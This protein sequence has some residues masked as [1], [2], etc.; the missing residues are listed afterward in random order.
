MM[1]EKFADYVIQFRAAIIVLVAI[2]VAVFA[3][4]LKDVS[5]EGS[6]RIWFGKDAKILTNYLDFREQFG[7]DEGVVITFRTPSGVFNQKDLAVITSI[8]EN[9]S[10]MPYFSSVVSIASFPHMTVPKDDPENIEINPFIEDAS[11]L[12]PKQ[13]VDLQKIAV[14]NQNVTNFLISKD[15]TTTSIVAMLTLEDSFNSNSSVV[16]ANAVKKILKPYEAK[17][18]EFA[19]TG[20][21]FINNAFIDIALT[22]GV[23]FTSLVIVSVFILLFI[24]LRSF[25]GSLLPMVVVISTFVIVLS[26][27]TLLGFKLNSFT[28][29]LPVFVVAIGIVHVIHIYW[30]WA[31]YT[32]E[33]YSSI[34]A[35]KHSIYKNF[36][37]VFLTSLTTAIGFASLGISEVVPIKTLGIATACAA[38]LAFILSVIFVPAVLSYFKHSKGVKAGK[39]FIDPKKYAKFI[40][41]HDKKIIW[42]SFG[43]FIFFVIGLTRIE[44][45]N[46]AIKYFKPDND[47]RKSIDFVTKNISAPMPM[48]VIVDSGKK[49]GVK[50]PDFLNKVDRFQLALK[51]H[52]DEVKYAN[53]LTTSIKEMNRLLNENNKSFYA[54]PTK[55][56]TV[57]GYLLLLS[58]SLSLDSRIDDDFRYFRVTMAT[59][60]TRT[61]KQLEIIHWINAW[62]EKES[63]TANVE[64]QTAMFAY[65]QPKIT[66]TL[67]YSIATALLMI[68]VVMLIIFRNIK[69]LGYFLIPNL[70]PIIT[71]IGVMGWLSIYVD[72]G[73]AISAAIVLGIAVD[74]AIHFLL[75]YLAYHKEGHTVQESLEHVMKYT[76]GAIVLTTMVLSVSFL[77][78]AGSSFMPNVYFAYTTVSALIIA[79]IADLLLLPALFSVKDKKETTQST[80]NESI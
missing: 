4:F 30:V 37:P 6:T 43:L 53:S 76:G 39:S 55:Q 11:A 31:S 47:I 22:D 60:N 12:T 7:T 49:D 65:M 50:S 5:V 41:Q 72:I 68:S 36:V 63:L 15:G 48:D 17:G 74:D 18:Y 64:G 25:L 8:E 56:N 51:E 67:I 20:T 19:L 57:A 21:P 69:L 70:F 10:E 44:V 2:F 71:A 52:F 34:E 66:E 78:L 23:L 40:V 35:A 32:K 9:L 1:I 24:M 28:A 75:K 33:G 46:N 61:S 13:L 29:N 62:W 42:I 79:L 80:H 16:I 59:N 3:I 73:V 26:V 14:K 38:M 27:Q 54:I 77:E 58:F 45:D